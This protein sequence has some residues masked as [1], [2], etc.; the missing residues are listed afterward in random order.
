MDD[1]ME[2]F[3]E[4][5]RLAISGG[6]SCGDCVRKT[7]YPIKESI[8]GAYDGVSAQARAPGIH[9]SHRTLSRLPCLASQGETGLAAHHATC[10]RFRLRLGRLMGRG[11][12]PEQRDGQEWAM[13]NKGKWRIWHGA[14]SP[15]ASSWW[16]AN[17]KAKAKA[18]FPSYN[19]VTPQNNATAS[20]GSVVG[21]STESGGLVTDMQAALN[22]ARKAELRVT[23]LHNAYEAAQEQWAAYDKAAKENYQKERRRS[24]EM[25]LWIAHGQPPEEP[26]ERPAPGL[27]SQV[28]ALFE[29]W[30]AEDGQDRDGV[31]RRA[32]H[33]QTTAPTTPLA[34]RVGAPMTPAAT[35][36]PAA[37]FAT[38]DPYLGATVDALPVSPTQPHL[39][40]RAAARGATMPQPMHLRANFP[41]IQARE[42][43]RWC[44]PR[45]EKFRPRR[46]SRR[47]PR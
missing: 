8:L 35:G 11:R 19:A 46:I 43:S 15:S 17:P 33:S 39:T 5:Y 40:A 37:A 42:T 12:N 27:S 30:A 10:P 32:M 22:I 14:Y 1:L 9:N 29:S 47:R 3:A 21:P 24:R 20:A 26:L 4:L 16:Y 28:E 6:Q 41:S 23:K 44:G 31:L 25:V 18:A 34:G 2:G 45:L 7:T 36:R 13:D 38:A